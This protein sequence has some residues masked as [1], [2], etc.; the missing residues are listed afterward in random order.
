MGKFYEFFYG[1]GKSPIDGTPW[2]F[3]LNS[4]LYYYVFS[5]GV[6]Y[7]ILIFKQDLNNLQ[8]ITIKQFSF[9]YREKPVRNHILLYNDLD[10]DKFGNIGHFDLQYW[11]LQYEIDT[12]E[13][14]T[15]AACCTRL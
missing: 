10:F 2:T 12:F 6:V 7:D 8:N 1:K 13:H 5:R 14:M 11:R 4:T 15:F 9:N 3:K